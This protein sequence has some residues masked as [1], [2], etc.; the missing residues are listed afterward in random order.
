MYRHPALVPLSR[1]HFDALALCVLIERSVAQ[2]DSHANV[3]RLAGKVGAAWDVELTNH[4]QLEEEL[5]FPKLP[6]AL[7]AELIAEHRAL[8]RLITRLRAEPC[9][10][11]LEQFVGD[12]RAHAHKEEQRYFQ[13]F[14][15]SVPEQDLQ[16][17]LPEL[18][19]RTLRACLTDIA[20]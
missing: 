19:T 12:L 3:A 13:E 5:I 20:S 2:D 4:F 7:A 17:L 16:H 8:E 14:Q 11:L 10:P 15:E 18:E 6:N 9:T 1:Q